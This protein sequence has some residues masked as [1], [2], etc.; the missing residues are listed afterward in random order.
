VRISEK[1]RKSGNFLK[2]FGVFV[3][4]FYFPVWALRNFPKYS[5]VAYFLGI[6]PSRFVTDSGVAVTS[7][8]GDQRTTSGGT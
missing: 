7:D 3:L 5:L 2:I 8:E 4:N 6:V 1:K